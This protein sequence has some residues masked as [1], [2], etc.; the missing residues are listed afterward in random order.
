MYGF[1]S[2]GFRNTSIMFEKGLIAITGPNGSGKSNVLDAIIFVLGE[3]SPKTLR[4]D[5][6][7]SLF[8]DTQSSSHRIIRV[9]L[10]LDNT[11]RGIPIDDNNITITREIEGFTG[12]SQYYLN[13]KKVSK[14]SIMDVLELV[15]PGPSKLH[16]VQQGMITRISE[17]NA[18]ERRS[19]IEDISGLS[20]FD[21]KKEEAIKQLNEA[22]R[23]LEIAF[24]RM[25][26]VKKR[27]TELEIERKDKI[28]YMILEKEIRR[29]KS[30]N[31]SNKINKSSNSLK[32]KNQ[33]LEINNTK[34]S[35]LDKNII[36][37]KN[38]IDVLEKEKHEY[39]QKMNQI[40][41]V[42]AKIE[43]TLSTKIYSLERNKAIVK[44]SQLKINTNER[45][46][47]HLETEKTGLKNKILHLQSKIN[48]LE[49][50]SKKKKEEI[51]RINEKKYDI[52]KTITDKREELSVILKNKN[53][54]EIRINTI[55]NIK[56][57]IEIEVARK[58][59][60]K[61]NNNVVHE[62]NNKLYVE[63]HS[64]L[65]YNVTL[66]EELE[67]NLRKGTSKIGELEADINKLISSKQTLNK[68]IDISENT[69]SKA[70]K[71][72]STHEA[73]L[74]AAYRTSK[75]DAS[76][77]II[78]KNKENFN[79]LGIVKDFFKWNK[80]YEKAIVSGASEW[81][82]SIVVENAEE[83]LRIAEFSKKNGLSKIRIIPLDIISN[84]KYHLNIN[85][86]DRN[87]LGTLDQFV[88][89]DI[90]ELARFIFGNIILTKDSVSAYRYATKGY[91]AVSLYGELF[92]P[93]INSL[94]L[95]FS[96]SEEDVI[97]IFSSEKSLNELKSSLQI[98]ENTITRRN[99]TIKAISNQIQQLEENKNK[100]IL[101]NHRLKLKFE[102][103]RE[104]VNK[105]KRELSNFEI[106][107][108][109]LEKELYI[110]EKYLQNNYKRRKIIEENLA[111]Y[112]NNLKQLDKENIERQILDL[113][114][115]KFN[116]VNSINQLNYEIQKNENTT[117]EILNTLSNTL[118][119]IKKLEEEKFRLIEENKSK[120]KEIENLL[121]VVDEDEKNI[122]SMRD[123]EQEI[124]N[125]SS[126]AYSILKRFDDTLKA[127][128]ENE[129]ISTRT[130]DN[131]EK[132]NILLK[133]EIRDL[134]QSK[135]NLFYD[136]KLLGYKYQS[137][138]FDV[139]DIVDSLNN[140]LENMKEK[141]NLKS[142]ET[143]IQIIEGY[144]SMSDRK[145]QLEKERNSITTF[146]DE[147][148]QEKKAVFMEA[149]EKVDKDIRNMFSA[150][151]GGN[152]WLE[153][154][155]PDNIFSKGIS[156]IVQ[157]PNKPKRESSSLSGGEKTI[158]GII[159]LL[160]LQSLKP[161]PFYLM[162]EVDAHLDALNTERLINILRE[163]SK[164]SQI[165]MVTL[166]DVTVGKSDLVYGVF[167]TEGVSQ[168]IKYKYNNALSLRNER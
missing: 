37:I 140:E 123:E 136:L 144:R 26:E 50:S 23:R 107:N 42:K 2:F 93:L 85:Y 119:Y 28:R 12:E 139:R 75:E 73:S 14:S 82:K 18:E 165:I 154:E 142:D 138:I 11:D 19:I 7:Q 6:F 148:I 48:D 1:K 25:S 29:Y 101:E 9:S 17:L 24:A 159:F 3:N 40:N 102:N 27:I 71:L 120:K 38:E 117:K 43:T 153:L 47:P 106:E 35:S 36:E 97:N 98:L 52:D 30:I 76:L 81:L 137:E 68:E 95:N 160:S 90:K 94:Y 79:I 146:I 62:K 16:I 152:A 122:K 61:R 67:E 130:R 164:K 4:V 83:M 151:T 65:T 109:N 96:Y 168:I 69:L 33:Q 86:N 13:K 156:L 89:T 161:S 145:N 92:E 162:D 84:I 124:I 80:I 87:I 108:K 149:F 110:I 51:I 15:I 31:I 78:F 166:K 60:L 99:D 132:E 77:A 21:E 116:V 134:E 143:Y 115:E 41:K 114:R 163:R 113:E 131:L 55:R 54:I 112:I 135:Q 157:F 128:R 141:I 125:S 74:D 129:K 111:G 22:D 100:I 53:K 32:N 66:M 103:L 91:K 46:I 150:I 20:Y 49:Q 57:K 5:R 44:E 126:D 58:E 39:M 121:L 158:A 155:D 45:R 64:Q 105:G 63:Q 70:T 118:N 72:V 34:I 104:S 127:L 10:T 8:H 88:T 59:E 147:I 167:P 56:N 133:K